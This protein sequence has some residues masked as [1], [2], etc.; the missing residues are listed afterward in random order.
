[1]NTTAAPFDLSRLDG[2]R[3]RNID[4]G[5][6]EIRQHALTRYCPE[7]GSNKPFYALHAGIPQAVVGRYN[8]VKEVYMDDDRFSATPVKRPG[9]ERFDFF[10]GMIT[11]S[12]MDGDEHDR[13]RQVLAPSF[14]P[15]ILAK[16]DNKMRDIVDTMLDEV[17]ALGGAFDCMNDF[18]GDVVVRILLDGVL[19]LTRAQQDVLVRM[20]KALPLSLNVAPG[21]KV[22]DTFISAQADTMAMIG[23]L[24]AE[25][26]ANPRAFDFISAMVKAQD[27]SNLLSDAEVAAN[28]FGICVAGQGTTAI[29]SAAMLM[30]LCQHR[31]QFD[32]VIANPAL[33]RQTVE[34]CLRYHGPGIFWF[35]RFATRDCEVDGV[36]I[37]EG[38]PVIVSAQSASYDPSVYPD[39]LV[40]NIHRNATNIPIFGMG[41]HH[42]IGNRLARQILKIVL[43][44]VCRRFPRLRLDDPD[45]VPRFEGSF[46]EL[47]FTSMPMHTGH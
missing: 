23:D 25:R 8:D 21:E 39:P 15:G 38:M 42:C 3:I 35:P 10:N 1:M 12:Q 22:P 16:L 44:K 17:E 7:W 14:S 19:G 45:F 40:F 13:V 2:S 30:T 37:L 11:V 24:I 47:R 28:I 33:I 6:D 46:G 34:E 27:E 36:P 4:L 26:R 29:S 31:D 9:F 5:S 32:E 20:N 41:R 18:A 43:E